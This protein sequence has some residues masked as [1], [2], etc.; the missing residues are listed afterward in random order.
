MPWRLL[1]DLIEPPL[2]QDE[3]KGGRPP[4]PL[5]TMLRVHLMQQWY[6]LCAPAMEEA[7]IEDPIM[8]RF[9]GIELINY[10]IPDETT[11]LFLRHL[12]E[13]HSSGEKIFETIETHSSTQ[14]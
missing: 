2:P 4:C 8:R 6:S 10:R 9:T 12:L 3:Q 5:V 11:I 13:K 7:L 1:I 14:G